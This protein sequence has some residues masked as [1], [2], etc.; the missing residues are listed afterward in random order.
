MFLLAGGIPPLEQNDDLF[1]FVLDP[2]LQLHQLALQ[3]EQLLEID[4]AIDGVAPGRIGRVVDGGVEPVIVEFQLQLL[5][6]RIGHILANALAQRGFGGQIG[7]GHGGF[8]LVKLAFKLLLAVV[9]RRG[10]DH[11]KTCIA[12]M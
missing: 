3:P 4:L 7:C 9:R 6:K 1:L 8:P 10:S 5:V 12:G 11:C 2:I